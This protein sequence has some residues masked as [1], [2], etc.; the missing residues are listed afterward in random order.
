MEE[1]KVSSLLRVPGSGLNEVCAFAYEECE[2]PRCKAQS[3]VRILAHH[4][5]AQSPGPS[6]LP[7]PGRGFVLMGRGREEPGARDFKAC[8][9]ICDYRWENILQKWVSPFGWP[10]RARQSCFLRP[11]VS[12]LWAVLGSRSLR[13]FS[14]DRVAAAGTT[15]WRCSSRLQ[16]S[17]A[18]FVPLLPT[19]D[20]HRS[21]S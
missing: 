11:G 17:L 18:L 10:S 2:T 15:Q 16:R 7:S 20:G 5:L 3:G 14:A 12:F 13:P 19:V 8:P 6:F 21:P 1:L 4:D 9:D